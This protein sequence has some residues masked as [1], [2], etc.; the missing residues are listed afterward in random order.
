MEAIREE[1][2][3]FGRRVNNMETFKAVQE[4]ENKNMKDDIKENKESICD[5]FNMFRA[6]D[7]LVYKMV[8]GIAVVYAVLQ[9]VSVIIIVKVTGG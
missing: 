1:L 2:N 3:G 4:T 7:K 6:M 8:G 5:I 9:T